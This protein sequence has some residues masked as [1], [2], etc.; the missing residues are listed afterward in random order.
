MSEDRVV[1]IRRVNI[2]EHGKHMH[3]LR[4]LSDDELRQRYAAAT[5]YAKDDLGE[6]MQERG[7]TG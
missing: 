2:E 5:S 7:L 4:Q 3:A 6:V 1:R